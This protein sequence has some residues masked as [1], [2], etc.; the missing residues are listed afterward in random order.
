M[1]KRIE[2]GG[3]EYHLRIR[4]QHVQELHEMLNKKP[5]QDAIMDSIDDPV[6][7]VIPFLWAAGQRDPGS[8]PFTKNDAFAL[9]DQMVDEG[10]EDWPS[11]ITELCKVSGFFKKAV[12]DGMLALVNKAMTAFETAMTK[13]NQPNETTK[14]D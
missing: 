2:V 1:Y 14:N 13:Q 8:A 7:N 3:K 12:A 4:A 6:T 11:L 10:F 5:Y 9:F